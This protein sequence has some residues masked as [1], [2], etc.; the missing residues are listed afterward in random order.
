MSERGGVV[1]QYIPIPLRYV[2]IHLLLS[3]VGGSLGYFLISLMVEMTFDEYLFKLLGLVIGVNAIEIIQYEY[4]TIRIHDGIVTGPGRWWKRKSF[5]VATI[6][7]SKS[8]SVSGW[9]RWFRNEYII[10][11]EGQKIMVHP[12]FTEQQREHLWQELRRLK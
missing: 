12:T 10:S 5:P 8:V 7:W 2:L 3:V 1:R 11:S 9:K 6:D 4:Q